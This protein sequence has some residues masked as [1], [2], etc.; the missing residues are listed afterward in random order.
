MRRALPLLLIACSDYGLEEHKEVPEVG[1]GNIATDPWALDLAG[2]CGE[3]RR[4]ILVSNEGDGT[5]TL[6]G[7]RLDGEG[8]TIDSAPTLPLDLGAGESTLV[9]VIGTEGSATLT[10]ESNDRDE[11]ELA[12][13]LSATA[14][15]PPSVSIS[16]PT[17]AE[18]VA[19]GADLVLSGLVT[20]AD[21]ASETL[22]VTWSSSQTGEI[23]STAP[24]PD[25][26]TTYTWP[27][28]DRATGAQDITLTAT[29]SCG[30]SASA[31]VSFCQDGAYSYDALSL[32][33]WHY[34]GAA[35]YDSSNNW[36]QLTPASQD[37]VGTAFETSAPV[38]ADNV[39]IEFY[40]YIGGGTGADGISLTA[41][42]AARYSTFLGGSGC[43]IGYGGSAN[44]TAGPALP[45]WSLEIDTYYNDGVDPTDADH[46]AFTFDGDVDGYSAWAA[47]PEMEDTGWHLV[48]VTVIAPR[49]T[50]AVD[51]TTYIDQDLSGNFSFSGYVG[52]TA[53]TG[54]DTNQH[55]IDE[56]VVTDYEC[57]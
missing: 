16:A 31:T 50:V 4:E 10:I 20:D 52:F 12:V 17:A 42:D 22:S 35:S 51:G 6:T 43:G 27:A 2:T 38:N 32:S 18:V 25:G 49:V 14:N 24:L 11:P 44:C 54:G 53:G 36:L 28:A 40:V 33:A 13:P 19:E 23:L 21:D 37:T 34:E 57:D 46:L 47:L 55:L 39:D 5:L 41:L 1:E 7:L 45:G 30:N 56:L 26:S 48:S 15:T 8:W 29:D 9:A 3:S